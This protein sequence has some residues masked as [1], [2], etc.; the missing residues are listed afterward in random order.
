[1]GVRFVVIAATLLGGC[2]LVIDT[3]E[4]EGASRADG[5]AS[6]DGAAP[7]G[8]GGQGLED[9]GA[10]G[11]ALDA[12]APRLVFV[13]S[14]TAPMTSDL[15]A[16]ATA[17]CHDEG[18]A[19]RPGKRFV[20]WLSTAQV[21]AIDQ[22]TVDGPWATSNGEMVFASRTAMFSG[23]LAHPIDR[24][25]NAF[26]A[27]PGLVAWTNTGVNGRVKPGDTA[28]SCQSFSSQNPALTATAGL[29]QQVDA[30][31]T[32]GEQLA[33]DRTAAFICIEN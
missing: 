4:L 2:S 7:T 19:A 27:A 11:D 32:D 16:V 3:S 30:R 13:S 26:V 12:S 24:H 1:M 8:D 6:A 28:Q 25:A 17:A 33:C 20:P 15:L 21:D 31:W 23:A 10:S 22:I 29:P 14:Q 5:A 9:A 18:R